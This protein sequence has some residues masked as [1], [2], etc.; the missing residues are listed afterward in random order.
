MKEVLFWKKEP[1][2]FINLARGF[3][4]R[5]PQVRPTRVF[6]FFEKRTACLIRSAQ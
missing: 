4:R 3:C 2:N 1:K 6:G 5:T